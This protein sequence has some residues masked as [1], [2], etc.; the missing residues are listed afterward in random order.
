[1]ASYNN[2]APTQVKYGNGSE[3]AWHDPISSSGGTFAFGR[4]S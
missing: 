4:S 1:M 2:L 3:G